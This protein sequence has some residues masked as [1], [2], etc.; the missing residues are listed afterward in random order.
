[1]KLLLCFSLIAALS[2][3]FNTP[4]KSN[5][6][7]ATQIVTGMFTDTSEIAVR[8]LSSKSVVKIKEGH[9][10]IDFGRAAFGTIQLKFSAQQKDSLRIRLGEKLSADYTIDRKPG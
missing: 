1:M 7:P 2:A 8:Y 3:G 4:T 5:P 9:Y 10:F 6:D